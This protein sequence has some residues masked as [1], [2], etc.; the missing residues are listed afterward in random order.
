MTTYTCFP[1][2][3]PGDVQQAALLIQQAFAPSGALGPEHQQRLQT[4]LFEIQKRPEAWGLVVPFLEEYSDPNVEFYGAHTAQVKIARDWESIPDE[5]REPLRDGLVDLT[6]RAAL[7]QK[8][9]P[10][11]RK[12]FVALS[13]LA[14]RLAPHHPSRWEQWLVNL[15]P[16][17]STRGVA[18]EY[19]FDLL[20]IAA[21]EISSSDLFGATKIRMDQTLRDAVPLMT[22]LVTAGASSAQPRVLQSA[23]K[24]L[25]AWIAAN[26][27]PGD[28]LTP[29]LP[30]LIGLLSSPA[31]FIPATEALDSVLTSSPLANGAGTK[32]LTE[33][34]LVWLNANGPAI[35]NSG[36]VD[37]VSHALC[38]LLV[39]LGDHSVS[40]IAAHLSSPLVQGFLRLMLG[41]QNLPGYF[42]VDEDESEMTLPFW[43]LLQEA[44]WSADTETEQNVQETVPHWD[45][46][47]ELYSEVVAILRKKATWPLPGELRSWTR[48]QREKFSVYRRDIGDSLVNA[49]YVLRDKMMQSLVD[50]VAAEVVRPLPHTWEVAEA[51]MHCLTSIQ[52]GVPLSREKTPIL[53][54]L[55]SQDV[56]GRLPTTGSD[57]IRLTTL[58]CIGAYASWFAAQDPNLLLTVINTVINSIHEPLLSLSAANALRDLCDSNRQALS[59][60][61]ASFGELYSK[62]NTIPDT[63]RNKILQSIASVIQALPPDE[64]IGPIQGII[65]PVVTKLM[66][67]LDNSSTLPDEARLLCLNELQALTGCAKGLTSQN[68]TF[69]DA[70]EDDEVTANNE[71]ME[72]ARAHPDIVKLREAITLAL[73]R[74]VDIWST[75]AT[76]ADA[77]GDV[78]KSITALPSDQT[79]I[80]L[81][82]MPLLQLVAVAARRQLTSVWLGLATMLVGQMNPPT[83]ST[84][85]VVPTPEAKA[86]VSGLLPAILEPCVQALRD[87]DQLAEVRLHATHALLGLQSHVTK[88]PDIAQAFFKFLEQVATNFIWAFFDLPPIAFAAMMQC[89]LTALA[90]QERYSLVAASSFLQRFLQIALAA[91]TLTE[92][93]N[94]FIQTYGKPMV[95]ALLFGIAGVAP[96]SVIPNLAELLSKLI[97]SKSEL[98]RLWMT[99]ILFSP[100]FENCKADE[101]A[102]EKFLKALMSSRSPKRTRDSAVQFALVA[103]GLDNSSFGYATISM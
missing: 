11:L 78:I 16:T 58:S 7:A 89:S 64:G 57:R 35:L 67:A 69:F 65:T 34:L 88:N 37:E 24:C 4:E 10:V 101:D 70:D 19:I 39:A 38:K 98:C 36:D 1:V 75:D 102:R 52:E 17:L 48:D 85:K 91:D 23:M 100:E 99:E 97:S 41:Y 53:A 29:L 15:V 80:T 42:G 81:S 83:A 8:P 72:R 71:R 2:L 92:Q 61:I 40:Y 22:Q 56:L 44:M 47:Q 13:S 28:D 43:Y 93:T 82:P 14:I 60:H 95:S 103:R 18:A 33:P 63:E 9:K 25:S 84:L 27:I 66:Q 3:A 54:R 20:S 90:V 55:F 74:T 31:S 45:I 46:A 87:S 21:E 94:N 96:R 12:L 79:L 73:S 49:Y 62:L 77:L 30:L 76:I 32:V 6:V 59:P 68:E 50:V 86:F 51:A 5:Q 26:C